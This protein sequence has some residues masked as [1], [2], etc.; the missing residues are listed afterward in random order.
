MVEKIRISLWDVFTFFLTGMLFFAYFLGLLFFYL[1]YHFDSFLSILGRA[2]AA[3]SLVVAPL[4]FLLVGILI[5]PIS[6]YTDRLLFRRFRFLTPA[7]KQKHADEESLLKA[8]ICSTYLGSLNGKIENPYA[9]CKEYVETKQLSTTFMVYLSR[10]GFYRNC[11][12]LALVGGVFLF[13][14]GSGFLH[15]LGVVVGSLVAVVVF[16]RRSEEF[17]AL[18]APTIY[19]AFLID[20]IRWVP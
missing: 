20:K 12:F 1:P 15:C 4:A 3:A 13:F 8:E 10:Y 16:K 9:I 14:L 5:E 17:Y 6:N 2:P 11:A 19:R 7:P 18:M